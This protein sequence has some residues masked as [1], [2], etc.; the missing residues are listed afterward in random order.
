M[1]E[2]LWNECFNILRD[3]RMEEALWN[4]CF[5]ILRDFQGGGGL[6]E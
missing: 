3:F 5:N 2:G 6:V 1:E 4:E